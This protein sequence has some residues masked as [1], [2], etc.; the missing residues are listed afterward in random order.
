MSN[1]KRLH[2]VAAVSTFL[3]EL[4]DLIFPFIILMIVGKGG[5]GPTDIWDYLPYI[6]ATAVIGFIFFSGIIRWLRFTYRVEEEE[7]R[8]EYGLFVKK[9][10][11]IPFERIQSLNF[12]EGILQRIFGLVKVKV[13]TAGSSLGEAEAELTAISKE[14]AK[15]LEE[16]IASSK[17][18]ESKEQELNIQEEQAKA[19]QEVLYKAAFSDLLI[20][21][22]TSGGAGVVI[23]AILAFLS[24]FQ[25]LIPYEKIFHELEH[26]VKNGIVFVIVLVVLALIVAWGIAVIGM[27]LKYAN[28]TL[29]KVDED[30]IITRGLIEKRQIT[31][32]LKRIQG[33]T[34]IENLIR[35]PFGYA[36]VQIESA[37]GS[38][39]DTDSASVIILPLI[40]KSEIKGILKDIVPEYEFNLAYSSLPK[41]ALTRYIFRQ[42]LLVIVPIVVISWLLWPYGLWSILL[43]IP[44]ALLGYWRYKDAGWNICG[45]QLSLKF[46]LFSKQ[47]MI[48][49]KNRIQAMEY[50][51]SWWQRR[52]NIVSLKATIKSGGLGKTGRVVDIDKQAALKIAEWFKP[53]DKVHRPNK[54]VEIEPSE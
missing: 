22:V 24:Q 1:P 12:S 7:L 15:N 27:L 44:M 54:E 5:K 2:P 14:E 35:Q 46:R 40:K 41:V 25:E 50:S 13:E 51:Q 23:A 20:M 48:L 18:K 32:P 6:T 37:G 43:L 33:V 29:K 42:L 47:T 26:V 49:K 8:I 30:L 36:T 3:K 19:P 34:M 17:R 39:T 52:K 31:V 21:G 9:K 4:K 10:R 11:Y 38:I 28:F 16:I 45:N 53:T